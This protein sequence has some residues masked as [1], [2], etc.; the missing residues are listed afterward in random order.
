V[1]H[2]ENLEYAA[3]LKFKLTAT[4]EMRQQTTFKTDV[5]LL[6]KRFILLISPRLL[7]R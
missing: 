6:G 2:S 5:Y 7:I 3:A 4:D 1:R